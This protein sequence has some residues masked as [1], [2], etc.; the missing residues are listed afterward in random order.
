MIRPQA[1]EKSA[2]HSAFDAMER[3]GQSKTPPWLRDIKRQAMDR[4]SE[5]G[6]PVAR[7]DNEEWKYTDVAPIAHTQFNIPT[8]TPSLTSSEIE[9]FTLGEG[10]WRTL[11]FVDGFYSKKLS[12][13][14]NVPSGVIVSDLAEALG[15]QNDLLREHLTRHAGYEHQAFTSINTALVNHGALVYVHEN[16][17]LPHPI[18]CLFINSGRQPDS[19]SN[20]RV[21]VVTGKDSK[22]MVIESHVG[23]Y[24]GRYFSNAVS[25]V[26]VGA[27]SSVQHYRLQRHSLGA[28]HVGTTQVELG[29]NASFHSVTLDLGGA[30]VRNNLNVVIA[31]EG[32]SC[33]LNGVY[34]ASG[35]QHIDNQVIIDH[36]KPHTTSRELYKGVLG[37]KSRA[38]FHGSIIVRPG[39]QKVD[40]RQED[41]NLLLSPQAEAFTKPA[42]WIYADDVKC[43]HGAASGQLDKDALFYLQSRGLSQDVARH[44]LIQGFIG[45]VI[46]S[47]AHDEF[48]KSASEMVTERLMVELMESKVTELRQ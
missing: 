45:E 29:E 40:A 5:L 4:F 35:T 22:A 47:I 25:E 42:F 37:G 11:V 12:S 8:S 44:L 31:S 2:Y 43:G 32:S 19:L 27:G 26:V 16:L 17:S 1:P 13:V 21:L 38:V 36:A 15:T 39:A 28:Y 33:T 23:L 14:V 24:G 41:K 7:R 34:I 18:H 46:D 6:F 48:K 9:A 20:P 30:L 3:N 10:R